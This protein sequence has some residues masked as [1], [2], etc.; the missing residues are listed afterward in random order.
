MLFQGN[1]LQDVDKHA[2]MWRDQEF[3]LCMV[4]MQCN[5][6]KFAGGRLRADNKVVVA[7]VKERGDA[8]EFI[9]KNATL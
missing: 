5:A 9:D 3:V 6:L 8:L 1:A 4:E 2:E 7:A